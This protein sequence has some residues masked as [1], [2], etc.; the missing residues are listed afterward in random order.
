MAE[1]SAWDLEQDP[2]DLDL[3]K[4]PGTARF[5]SKPLLVNLEKSVLDFLGSAG[6]FLTAI[7]NRSLFRKHPHF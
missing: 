5:S 4:D 3:N 2:T 1:A 6:P 7:L